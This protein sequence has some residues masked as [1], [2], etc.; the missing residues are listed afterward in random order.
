MN[1]GLFEIST[2]NLPN[3]PQLH[4][5][6]IIAKTSY[7]ERNTIEHILFHKLFSKN[8]IHPLVLFDLST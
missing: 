1:Y 8:P 4:Q 7:T 6:V 3:V 2:R 5:P